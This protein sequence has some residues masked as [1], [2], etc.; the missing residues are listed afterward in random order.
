MAYWAKH[1]FLCQQRSSVRLLLWLWLML[2]AGGAATAAESLSL[3]SATVPVQEQSQSEERRALRAGLAEVLVKLSGDR[4]ALEQSE[5]AAALASPR[6]Y[7]TSF[8][9]AGEGEQRVMQIDFAPQALDQLLRRAQLTVWPAQRQPLLLWLQ[10]DRLPR[11]R[12]W[13]DYNSDPDLLA[14][15]SEVMAAR[16][17]P[18]RLP[19]F[20]LRDRLAVADNRA[21][22]LDPLQLDRASSPYTDAARGPRWAALRLV[23]RSDGSSRGSWVLRLGEELLQGELTAAPEIDQWRQW[24]HAVVDRIAASEAYLPVLQADELALVIA[25]VAE[26]ASYRQLQQ[27]LAE[28]E[29]LRAVRLTSVD[30]Y[31]VE[32]AA[33]IE[34]D[35]DRVLQALLASGY[36][37]LADDA[38]QQSPAPDRLALIWR[39]GGE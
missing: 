36:F 21:L 1:R 25:A 4:N 8:G 19:E 33:K 5:V 11:G 3:Y 31:R 23:T 16:G 9:F 38:A 6:Q 35:R 28:I 12:H 2:A 29:P 30:G 39:G 20:D 17:L 7:A 15:I 32:L 24:L 13:L 10:V 14:V 26:M 22:L 34:G 18:W 27:V 37:R